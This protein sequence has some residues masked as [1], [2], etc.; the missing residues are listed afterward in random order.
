MKK[1]TLLDSYKTIVDSINKL[2]LKCISDNELLDRSN[3]LKEQA[4]GGIETDKLIIEGFALVK[5]AIRRTLGFE[6]YDVQLLGA[7]A[8]N[9]N[10]LIE[11]QT[12]EGKTLTAVFPAYLNGLYKKGVHILTFN[13]YL[14]RRDALWMKPVYEMLGLS[15]GFVQEAM[16]RKEKREAYNCDITYVTAKEAGFDYL[17]DSLCYDK[18]DLIHRPFYYAIVDEA[19]SILIDEARIPLVIAVSTEEKGNS[20][21]RVSSAVRVL[22]PLVD[23]KTDE[24]S[25]NVYL[26]ETGI[27]HIEAELGCGNLFEEGNIDLF[28]QVNSALFAEVLL[29]KDVDYIVRKDKIEMVDE[30]TG[31]VAENR[32]WPD[33]LQAALES[34]ENIE[35]QAKGRIMSQ[36]TLQHFIQLYDNLAGMTGTASDAANEILEFY[37]ME[38]VVIPPNKPSIRRDLE[39]YVFT[40]KEAKHKAL[41]EEIEKVH[42][43]GQPILIGTSSVKESLYIAAQLSN[44]GVKCQVLNAKND[45]LEAHIIE[46]AGTL[47]AVTVSTNMA[48]RGTDILLGGI[49]GEHREKIKELG[50]L[51]VIGT[52]RYESIRIDK[53]LMG[54]AGRQGDPGVTCFFVSLEDDLMVKYGIDSVIPRRFQPQSQEEPLSNPIF[55][56]KIAQVQRIVQGQNSDL[57]REL[58]KYSDILD[59]Q[60]QHMY[61]LRMEILNDK[62]EDNLLQDNFVKLHDEL[63]QKHSEIEIQK[64]IKNIRLFHMEQ[65]WADYLEMVSNLKETIHLEA[66][67]GKDPLREFQMRLV[68]EFQLLQEIIEEKIKEDYEK[69]EN[70]EITFDEISERCTPLES[71]WTYLVNDNSFFDKVGMMLLGMGGG[72]AAVAGSV[73]AIAITVEAVINKFFRRKK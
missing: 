50:G 57:R 27:E 72:A 55:K 8:L 22:K 58:Y 24:Y 36:I 73:A 51:Y 63:K 25:R 42:A 7:I 6:A 31:R 46:N 37:G 67:S 39:P 9:N 69:L 48:G 20:L 11:M 19:D 23:Y 38:V 61:N 16:E 4:L 43:T 66:I 17:R 53:Q 3:K 15:V 65:C 1:N 34:K 47:G 28:A 59:R 10:N 54:R 40:H 18:E 64:F 52:N 13:D 14:A 41:V 35:I 44:I 60:R 49:K 2:Q 32:H 62:F 30:F 21:Q 33:G 56:K 70:S 68:K 26:T 29:Q 12:G 5:E 45:E 71:T